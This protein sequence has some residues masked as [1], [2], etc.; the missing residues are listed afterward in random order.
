MGQ[1]RITLPLDESTLFL[2]DTFVLAAPDL[3]KSI[4]Q[5]THDVKLVV[6]NLCLLSMFQRCFAEWL[7][8][9]HNRQLDCIATLSAHGI[10]EQLQVLFGAS[11]SAQPDRS[12]LV[13]IGDNNGVGV[14]FTDRYFVDAN[15]PQLL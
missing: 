13:K 3:I 11:L 5:M 10:E 6:D 7:P 12:P 14:A 1:Q 2:I 8:H 4:G 15:G 9:I